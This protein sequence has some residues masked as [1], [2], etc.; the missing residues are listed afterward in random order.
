LN[1]YF[2]GWDRSVTIDTSFHDHVV[3]CGYGRVGS[4]VG[5]ALASLSV[6]YVVIDYN[7]NVVNELKK[8]GHPVIYG[9][10]TEREVLEAA[11]I[12]SSK[13]LVLT[14]PDKTARDGV[15]S[16]PKPLLQR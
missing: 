11:G 7:Q 12:V 13:A 1:K 16:L 3:I 9:D 2:A 4:W 15:I 6:P 5:K 10:P 14:I 8:L